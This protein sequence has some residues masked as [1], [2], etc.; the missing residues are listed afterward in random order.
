MPAGSDGPDVRELPEPRGLPL[1][2]TIESFLGR[3][4]LQPFGELV[5]EYGPLFQVARWVPVPR[6]RYGRILRSW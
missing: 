5:G 2:A 6:G 3:D 1:L 4:L